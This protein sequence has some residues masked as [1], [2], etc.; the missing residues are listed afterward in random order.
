MSSKDYIK[1]SSKK[2][3]KTFKEKSLG[4]I[5][6]VIKDELPENFNLDSVLKNISTTIPEKFFDNIDYIFIGDFDVFKE[7]STNAMYTEGAIYVTNDQDDIGDM[8]DDIVHEIAHSVEE[9]QFLSIYSDGSLEMEFLGK[10]ER[11]FHLLDTEGYDYLNYQDFKNPE[12]S[13]NFDNILYFDIGYA[14]LSSISMNLFYSP[15]AITSL[16]EYFANGFEAFYYHKDFDKLNRISPVLFM[17]IQEL[18]QKEL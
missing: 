3:K 6:V 16:R 13:N 17:K 4:N 7:R 18:H 15:Y 8:V 14:Y 12:Y 5:Q 9:E 11:L 1:S 2:F 10:R